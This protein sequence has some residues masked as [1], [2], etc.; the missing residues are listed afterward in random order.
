MAYKKSDTMMILT[1]RTGYLPQLN[2][3]GPIVYPLQVNV[4]VVYDMLISGIKLYQ[5]DPVTKMT[6]ELTIENIYDDKKF[7][8]K[9][10]PKKETKPANEAKSTVVLNGVKAADVLPPLQENKTTEPPVD[11][12]NDAKTGEGEE[13]KEPAKDGASDDTKT[14][15]KEENKVP[16]KPANEP[17]KPQQ[18]NSSKRGQNRNHGGVAPTN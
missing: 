16:E 6:L 13:V 14:P 8:P 12:Q 3:H 10:E 15:E 17:A 5:F 9:E 2:T 18:P 11:N 7:E 4:G 1:T